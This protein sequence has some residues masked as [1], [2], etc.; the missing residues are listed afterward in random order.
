MKW[1]HFPRYWP[2]VRE[3]TGHRWIPYTKASDVDVFVDLRLNKR[4]CKQSWGW[5]FETLSLS[6][7]RRR[8]VVGM[9]EYIS[10]YK[11]C[12]KLKSAIRWNMSA[13]GLITMINYPKYSSLRTLH[14]LD[15][16]LYHALT[17]YNLKVFLRQHIDHL[18]QDCCN[19]SAL[20]MELLQ[21]YTKPSIYIPCSEKTYFYEPFFIKEWNASE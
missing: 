20:T 17:L 2:F 3:F 14:G 5:W 9:N 21:Y 1:R 16:G 7:W 8:N 19:S 10:D 13:M 11:P 12:H 15:L 4:F 6:L 18:E